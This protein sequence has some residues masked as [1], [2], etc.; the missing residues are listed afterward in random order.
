MIAKRLIHVS[1]MTVLTALTAAGPA[2]GHDRSNESDRFWQ[3]GD[4]IFEIVGE[5]SVQSPTE[6]I[7]YGYLSSIAGLGGI[8]SGDPADESTA[9]FTFFNNAT[10]VQTNTRGG[11][12]VVRREGT[13]TVYFDAT[14]DG[15]FGDSASFADGWPVQVSK[16][17]HQV[18]FNPATGQFTVVFS[19]TILGAESFR[20]N[21]ARVQLGRVGG[22]FRIQGAGLLESPGVFSLAGHAIHGGPF[23]VP[24]KRQ[25]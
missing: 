14:P 24:V 12:V 10:T 9:H 16:W 11:L 21:G 15:S 4:V 8:F 7:Q 25:R 1:C 13:M 2:S 22:R 23:L 3:P 18:I 5:A 6:A 20:W 17:E 19:N